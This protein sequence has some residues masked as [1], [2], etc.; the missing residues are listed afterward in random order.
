MGHDAYYKRPNGFPFISTFSDGGLHND[1]WMAWREKWANEIYFV[2]DFD[3]T[4]GYY[5]SDPGWR[6]Y[7]E[8]VVDGIFS[9]ESTWPMRGK[10]DTSAFKDDSWVRE[11]VFSHDKS[12]MLG[13][14]SNK[15]KVSAR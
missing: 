12:Y 3:G 7:W 5:L 10:S 11:G 8:D 6:E 13:T 1:V 2:P 15:A 9:W 14:C 4:D